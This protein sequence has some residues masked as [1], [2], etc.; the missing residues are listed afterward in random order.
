[1]VYK[2]RFNL[3]KGPRYKKWK[4]TYPDKRVE[5]LEPKDI[6]LNMTNAYL[7]NRYQCSEKIFKGANKMVCAWIECEGLIIESKNE[8]N[9]INDNQ[10]ISFNPR[11]KPHWFNDSGENL[12]GV[13]FP[14]LVTI[15]KNVYKL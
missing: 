1:M 13:T 12:D 8:I 3:G 4:I 9:Q 6:K 11:I 10:L 2:V 5:Y 15:N 7:K 14:N